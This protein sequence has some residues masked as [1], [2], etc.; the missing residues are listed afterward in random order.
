[1]NVHDILIFDIFLIS[2]CIGSF[3]NVVIYRTPIYKSDFTLNTPSSHCPICKHPL[4]WFEN[5]PVIA[6]ILL[7]GKCR[8]CKTKISIKYPLIELATGISIASPVLLFD[9]STLSI[10]TGFLVAMLIPVIW[11]ILKKN[12]FNNAMKYWLFLPLLT[13]L[14][15]V[16]NLCN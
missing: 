14:S 12:K 8:H 3:L 11:W 6:W 13:I 1:M 9:I 4:S 10:L 2:L 7:R 16:I 15:M 5:I